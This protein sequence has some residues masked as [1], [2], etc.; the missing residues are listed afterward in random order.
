MGFLLLELLL[1]YECEG[2]IT[3]ARTKLDLTLYLALT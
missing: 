1:N 3:H 2:G